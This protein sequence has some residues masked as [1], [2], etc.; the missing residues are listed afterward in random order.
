MSSPLLG[1]SEPTP[2]CGNEAEEAEMMA[3]DVR[4]GGR[5]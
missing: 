2:L 4:L 3:I 5:E 1:N